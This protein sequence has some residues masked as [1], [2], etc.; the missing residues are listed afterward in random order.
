MNEP[1][2]IVADWLNG[3]TSGSTSVTA[4]LALSYDATRHA[5]AAR[6]EIPRDGSATL[7]CV[8]VGFGGIRYDELA[9]IHSGAAQLQRGECTVVVTVAHRLQT[10]ETGVMRTDYLLRA[11]LGSLSLLNA[12]GKLAARERNGF[13]LVAC[14]SVSVAPIATTTEDLWIGSEITLLYQSHETTPA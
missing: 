1:V 2:R 7:P 6:G 9:Q 10:T 11:V 12:P 8:V 4:I 5:F 14:L 13:Q 3:T